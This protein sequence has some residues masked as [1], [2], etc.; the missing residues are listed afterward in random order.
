MHLGFSRAK[1]A[2]RAHRADAPGRHPRPGA[3]VPR[4]PARVLRRHAA[5]GDDR[6]RA[7]L[8]PRDHP[9]RRADHR[10][11]RHDPGPDPAAAGPAVPRVRASAWCSSPTTC[12]SSPRSASRSRS[13]TAG[14]SSR[15]GAVR[16]VLLDPR[17]PYTLGLVRSAPDFEYVRE[18]LVPI[19]GSPPS[20][21]TPPPGCRFHP[22]CQFAEEDCKVTPTPLRPLPGGRATACLHYERCL[23]AVAADRPA[24]SRPQAVP[25]GPPGPSTA[26]RCSRRAGSRC[27]SRSARSWPRGSGTS[28]ACCTPSTGS[29]W[30]SA[31]ARRWPW[32]A[33][34]GR[35]SRRSPWRW[36]G[37]SRADRGEITL[38]RQAAARPAGPARTSAG[39]RWS[40]RTRIPR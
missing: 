23:E 38:R 2:E 15:R 25:G 3:A 26:G 30:T 28:S 39:S 16:D 24:M 14:R 1:A 10:A 37:C 4:V 18:S 29:T 9:L 12:R 35:A 34:R 8:R 6:D 32:S 36:P 13:C 20:L 27:T 31:A 7:V 17:H 33:S 5:A 19:P 40:S 21:V 22:R 11:R